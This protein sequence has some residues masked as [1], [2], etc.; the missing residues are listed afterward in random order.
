MRGKEIIIFVFFFHFLTALPLLSCDLDRPI[1]FAG[2]D[3]KSNHFHTEVARYILEKGYDCDTEILPGTNIPLL[4]GV[5]QGHID[6]VMEV[7]KDNVNKVWSRALQRNQVV[8]L[9]LNFS[10]AKQGWFVPKYLV[11]G[12]NAL[13]PDL[14]SVGDMV[15]Y[16]ALFRDPE[17]PSKGRFYNCI[18][19]WNCEIIN[20]AKLKAY[21]LNEHFTNFRPGTAA[22]LSAA[23]ASAYKK[24]VPILTYYWQPTWLLG[25]YEMIELK[26]PEFDESI[27]SRLAVEE[28]P[29]KATAYP[30]LDVYIGVNKDFASNAPEIVKFLKS[31]RT[32]SIL[33]NKMLAYMHKKGASSKET[34]E[35]FL[36]EYP[37]YWKEWV[38]EEIFKE[39]SKELSHSITTIY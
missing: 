24:E 26:E 34:A 4:Q 33:I 28:N 9:G 37:A 5:A 15:K 2:L 20:S 7:W 29:N 18:A 13:A 10:D 36:K 14:V 1:V 16:K 19:G 39:I 17:E 30:V 23:I 35:M 25:I 12:P 27:F 3:W 22:S 32:D 6:I 21:G 11:K 38:S 31:Y 8:E